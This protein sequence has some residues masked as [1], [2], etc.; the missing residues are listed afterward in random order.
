MSQQNSK[1][2]E[3]KAGLLE[4]SDKS[5]V[6]AEQTLKFLKRTE[7]VDKQTKKDIEE[8]ANSIMKNADKLKKQAGGDKVL[9]SMNDINKEVVVIATNIQEI[10]KLLPKKRA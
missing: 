7:D 9:E 10:G 4:F 5:K 3:R 8:M 1:Y 6:F 2:A